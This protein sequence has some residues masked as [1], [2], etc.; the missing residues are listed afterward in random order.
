MSKARDDVLQFLD[1]LE[2]TDQPPQQQQQQEAVGGD[3]AAQ[4][5]NSPPSASPAPA[6]NSGRD[7]AAAVGGD[8]GEQPRRERADPKEVLNFLDK[9]TENARKSTSSGRDAAAGALQQAE[10]SPQKSSGSDSSSAWSW[11]NI[12]GQA[13]ALVEQN[14]AFT[15]IKSSIDTL[16][17]EEGRKRLESQVRGFVADKD[18]A[19]FINK[20]G[21][22]IKKSLG[23]VMEHLAPPIPEHTLFEI[24]VVSNLDATDGVRPWVNRTLG[25]VADYFEAGEVKVVDCLGD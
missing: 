24:Y 14:T 16:S 10:T 13:T 11:G 4:T 20:L 19:Q 15:K 21:G 12:W 3:R 17:S 23:T 9:I 8:S 18:K 1:T 25:S 5:V 22:D 6:S 7:S 2:L